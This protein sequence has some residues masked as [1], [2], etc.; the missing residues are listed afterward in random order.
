MYDRSP[1]PLR[2]AKELTFIVERDQFTI[3]ILPI[4]IDFF[5]IKIPNTTLHILQAVSGGEHC[6][7]SYWE[8]SLSGYSGSV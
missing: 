3:Y 7:P 6:N 1:L 2:R 4:K 8:P 5:T